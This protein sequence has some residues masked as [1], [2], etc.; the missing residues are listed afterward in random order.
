MADEMVIC[1]AGDDSFAAVDLVKRRVA[2]VYEQSSSDAEPAE[3]RESEKPAGEKGEKICRCTPEHPGGIHVHQI[4][5]PV[6][7]VCR[8]YVRDHR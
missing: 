4:E 1:Y 5:G 8:K 7:I 6:V 2:W 3:G